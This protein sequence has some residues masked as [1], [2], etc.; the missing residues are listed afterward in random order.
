MKV[1]SL[2]DI[3]KTTNLALM[4]LTIAIAAIGFF[5]WYAMKYASDSMKTA[6]VNY[7]KLISAYQ[8]GELQNRI[9]TNITILLSPESEQHHVNTTYKEN[10]KLMERLENAWKS[11]NIETF[12]NANEKKNWLELKRA[13][14]QW[15]RNQN[16]IIQ[17]S[18]KLDTLGYRKRHYEGRRA[19][20]EEIDVMVVMNETYH[21]IN[22]TSFDQVRSAL[23]NIQKKYFDKSTTSSKFASQR[24]QQVSILILGFVS[25]SFFSA[26]LYAFVMG[27]R[28]T[29]KNKEL[30]ADFRETNIK[31]KQLADEKDQALQ[32]LQIKEEQYR[33]LVEG[34]DD[35][36]TLVDKNGVLTFINHA[37]FKVYGLAPEDCIGQV[38]FDFIHPDDQ[39]YTITNF[40][41]WVNNKLKHI[42]HENRQVSKTGQ[43]FHMH[44]TINL[45]FDQSGNLISVASIGRDITDIKIAEEKLKIARDQLEVKVEERTIDYKKA[46][47]EAELAN[48][49]KSEFLANISHELRTPMHHILHYSKYGGEMVNQ[50]TLE[51]IQHYFSQIR[52]SGDRLL[53]LINDLLD[54][55]KLEAGQMDLDMLKTDIMSII[56]QLE[57][58][59]APVCKKKDV[60]LIIESTNLDTIVICDGLKIEQVIRNL[61]SNSIK[62]TPEGKSITIAFDLKAILKENGTN[63][64][65]KISIIDEGVGI[66]ENELVSV[67]DKFL[68]SS[69]TNTKAGGTGLGLSICKEL[70]NAHSGKIWAENN[71]K[72]GATFSFFIPYKQKIGSTKKIR[73]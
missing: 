28:I 60:D 4:T 48:K 17:Y 9:N 73:N 54:L 14:D 41:A 59:F 39:R 57:S 66:P 40:D 6:L 64:M 31:L 51:K 69:R 36:I 24:L 19:S 23:D 37:S 65:L 58:E 1:V 70:I 5:A 71:T 63:N 38:A 67:F 44:W 42:T 52:N 10:K 2:K 68:Q 11:V 43:I 16:L 7:P 30:F 53:I 21:K 22:R 72:G 61:I 27:N 49:L 35:L 18:Q 25:V 8:I 12:A 26:I 29:R 62:F 20:I 3:K 46:K 55:S 47:D 34:T 45:H 15:T 32:Q 33:E 50:V 56:K 13:L